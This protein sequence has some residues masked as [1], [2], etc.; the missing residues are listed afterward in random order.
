MSRIVVFGATGY[1]GQLAARALVAR[2]ARDVLLAGRNVD[3]L[4]SLASELGGLE[5]AQVELSYDSLR[6]IL[7]EGDV[8]VSLVGPFVSYG[9]IA[10]RAAIDARCS[11][12]LDSAGEG[13]FLRDVFTTYHEEAAVAGIPLL[14]G[15]GADWVPGNFVGALA[16]RE[17]GAGATQSLNVDYVITGP[18]FGFSAGSVQSGEAMMSDPKPPYALRDGLIV[19]MAP[20]TK[21][22]QDGSQTVAGYPVSATEPFALPRLEPALKNVNVHMA[23]PPAAEPETDSSG[24]LLRGPSQESRQANGQVVAAT[25]SAANGAVLIRAEAVA[26]NGYDYTAQVLAWGAIQAATSGIAG[27]G[28]LGPVEAFGLDSLEQFHAELGAT[29]SVTGPALS[30]T[31]Q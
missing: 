9:E 14:T 30:G 3:A 1:T 10:V 11:G 16:L 28:A 5:Y 2:G 8:L 15:F 17:A 25:A 4:R 18:S 27:V 19:D 29:V 22:L 23:F 20:D 12:Y 13:P 7:Q 31:A 6:G 21:E 26:L 24:R